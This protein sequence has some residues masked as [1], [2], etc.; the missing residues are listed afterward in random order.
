MNLKSFQ[1]IFLISKKINKSADKLSIPT[2]YC[3]I[4]VLKKSCMMRYIQLMVNIPIC[5]MY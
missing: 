1:A 4:I 3:V 2:D 5:T